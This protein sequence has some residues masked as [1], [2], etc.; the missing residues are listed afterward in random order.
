M[1]F[2]SLGFF[3]FLLASII[4]FFACP[5]KYRWTVLLAI[6]V[7]F[8]A[9]SGVEFLPFIL[10]STLTVYL[11]TVKIG[12]NWVKQDEELKKQAGSE[13]KKPNRRAR[14]A[15]PPSGYK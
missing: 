7:A 8:Y 14:C 2:L 9:I 6:S 11:A 10:L 5:L 13:Q 12:K 4:L 1:T 3:A 15:Q